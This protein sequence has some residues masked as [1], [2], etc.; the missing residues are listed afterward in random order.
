MEGNRVSIYT[1]DKDYDAE[2]IKGML[3]EHDI[4]VFIINKR[5]SVCLFGYFELYVMS[6]DVMKAKTLIMN[7]NS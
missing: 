4:E 7:Y 3:N 2:I 6:E 1:T 5:D